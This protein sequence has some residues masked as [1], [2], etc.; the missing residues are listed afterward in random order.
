MRIIII[1]LLLLSLSS[2]ATVWSSAPTQRTVVVQKYINDLERES[3]PGT[4]HG[5]WV[6]NMYQDAE[7]PGQIDPKGIYYRPPHK[8]VVEIRHEKFQRAQY[9]DA[10]GVYRERE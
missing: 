1:S 7:I 6:E 9:P 2:C 8:T 3:I 5:P 4:V 10:D